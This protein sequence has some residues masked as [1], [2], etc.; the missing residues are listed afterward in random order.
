MSDPG[1]KRAR[2][3]LCVFCRLHHVPTPSRGFFL[4][5]RDRLA[6]LRRPRPVVRVR[7]SGIIPTGCRL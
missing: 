4:H 1:G 2:L 7:H 5:P 6:G 3:S